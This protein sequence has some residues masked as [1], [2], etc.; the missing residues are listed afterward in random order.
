MPGVY[1]AEKTV[2]VPARKLKISGN[3][4]M[5]SKRLIAASKIM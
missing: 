4:K 5:Y 2:D 1:F 3:D